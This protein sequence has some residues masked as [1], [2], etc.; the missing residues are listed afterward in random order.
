MEAEESHDLGLKLLAQ[1]LRTEACRCPASTTA[2]SEADAQLWQSLVRWSG[3]RNRRELL[4]DIGLGRKIAVIVAK[5]LARQM[6]EQG[7]GRMRSRC[8]WAAMRST[9]RRRPRARSSSTAARTRR[10][11]LATCCQPIPATIV[12]YLGRGEGLTVHTAECSVGKR[13]FERDPERWL[14]VD[15]SDRPVRAFRT[16]VGVLVRNGTGVLAE[17]AQAVS[18]AEADIAHIDMDPHRAR[19][20]HRTAA[21]AGGARPPA[22]GGCAAR[23]A[24]QPVGD[25]VARI[26]PRARRHGLRPARPG[27]IA[28][29][30]HLEAL[31][32][33]WRHQHHLVALARLQQRPRD[34]GDPADLAAP[35]CRTRRCP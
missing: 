35:G 19:R 30:D 12:G 25:A 4:I 1:A 32:P 9:T 31:Q 22:S 18:Q 2:T 23:G 3:N 15:W 5:R 33:R 21:D 17:I 24:A 14:G 6:I 20:D 10:S 16:A 11:Q 7:V 34:R 29:L 26:R 8:R 28:H 27:G 13:L